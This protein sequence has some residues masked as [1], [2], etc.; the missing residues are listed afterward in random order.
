MTVNLFEQIA[1][2]DYIQLAWAS[3]TGDTV[4]ATAPAGTSPVHPVSPALIFTASF[5]SALPT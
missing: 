5:V 3:D 1:A 4:V 2:N